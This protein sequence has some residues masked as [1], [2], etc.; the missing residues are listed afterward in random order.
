MHLSLL[1]IAVIK[2]DQKQLGEE[3]FIWSQSTTEE[4]QKLSQELEAEN[5]KEYCLL[6]NP[7][8]P[9]WLAFS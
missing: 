7:Q 9:I 2:C 5:M 6:A 8:A 4:S 3:G 1:F